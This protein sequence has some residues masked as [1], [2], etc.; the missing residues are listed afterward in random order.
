MRKG[1]HPKTY[2]VTQIYTDRSSK[3]ISSRFNAKRI[4]E[5]TDIRYKKDTIN[6]NKN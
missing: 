6:I 3:K 2:I 1:I 4:K 5:D